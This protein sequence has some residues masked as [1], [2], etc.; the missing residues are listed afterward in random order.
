MPA[1]SKIDDPKFSLRLPSGESCACNPWEALKKIAEAKSP[2]QQREVIAS[3]FS[4]P[5]GFNL[6]AHQSLSV[7]SAM[8]AY[9]KRGEEAYAAVAT[10]AELLT[11]YPGLGLSDLREM[12]ELEKM[13]LLSHGY[14]I[15]ARRRLNFQQD[16]SAI[17]DKDSS[18]RQEL[19]RVAFCNDQKTMDKNL[20][21]LSRV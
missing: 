7:V 20:E 4:F 15:E 18:L 21:V 9:A 17:F 19:V 3:E 2:R 16:I 6:T 14:R 5:P 12:D 11:M 8:L 13:A 10:N 1:F